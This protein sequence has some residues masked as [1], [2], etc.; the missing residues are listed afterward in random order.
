MVHERN[1]KAVILGR[2]AALVACTL[3][4]ANVAAAQ[5]V[6]VAAPYS[7]A[8]PNDPQR[9]F[10]LPSQK[11]EVS[12]ALAEFHRLGERGAWERAF[13]ELEKVQQ[14]PPSALAPGNDGLWAP[15]RQLIRQ[16]LA[17]MPPGGKQ[18]YR[19]FHDADAKV[20]LDGAKGKEEA[21]KLAKI[22]NDHFVTASGDLAA[23]RLGDL[24]FERGEMDKAAECWQA[25]IE[26]RPESAIPRVRL[27][28]K[29][30]IA[31]ARAG[32]WSEFDELRRQV[33][34]RHAGES[35]VLGGKQI[36]AGQR[37]DELAGE[38][39]KAAPT[40]RVE[41]SAA[42]ESDLALPQG[43]S[44]RWQ[45]RLFNA[46][47]A[48]MLAQA[49]QNWGWG[50]QFPVR[51][52]SPAAVMDGERV[53]M[54]VMGY[55]MAVD[56]KT[57]KLV[58]RSAKLHELPQ[59]LQQSQ[60]HFPEQYSLAI[61]G[62]VLWG[63]TR[64]V[65]QIGQHGQNFRLA[66]WEAATGKPG[67]T[68]QNLPELQNWNMMGRPLPAGDRVYIAAGKQGQ[69][70]ELHL[71][72]VAAADGKLLWS[73]HLGTHQVDQGQ[74]FYRRTSQPSLAL[75]AGRVIV[76][77]HAGALVAVDSRGGAIEWGMIYDSQM[78]DTNYWYNRPRVLET[79]GAPLIAGNVLYF[80]SMRS[81]RLYAI[82]LAA[83][84]LLWKRPVGESSMLIGVDAENIY[85]GGEEVLAIELASQKLR[86]ATRLP[87][88]TGWIKPVL[89]KRFVYQFT[90]RGV[91][92]LDKRNGDTARL[93]RG[94]D[95]D[96][97]GGQ[98]LVADDALV[99]VSNLAVTCYPMKSPAKTDP[100]AV[101]GNP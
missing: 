65:A 24:Y 44:L 52:M 51:E 41:E 99:T 17:E 49:G 9:P 91:F 12:E 46:P 70:A 22:F 96:S 48:Q 81:A 82:D 1:Q 69:G 13:K 47:Q 28:V 100:A 68:S 53:Y 59:K 75:Y 29:A 76:D 95:L 23:D 20:L 18:A 72:A 67:W 16:A 58:W 2:V 11:A 35:V 50:N 74:M 66:R 32:R 38:H 98:L 93:F 6:M 27:L 78:P 5:V 21:E 62:G 3:G 87:V 40:P 56:L 85:L 34:E 101:S 26:F 43:D 63:V 30:A 88:G 31:L 71:L 83:P 55:L 92:E 25:V 8:S 73:T 33:R 97:L 80:K 64:D 7:A 39:A 15:T 14:A 4:G 54:N 84:K 42:A 77:T 10:N 61:D 36:P 94:A 45:F 89:T 37:L 86:W 57:G 90:P 19:L 79:V 60:Y